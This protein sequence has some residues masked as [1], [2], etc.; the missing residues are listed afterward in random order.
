VSDNGVAVVVDA[1][2]AEPRRPSTKGVPR[3]PKATKGKVGV[4]AGA[5]CADM[6]LAPDGTNLER[7]E[8]SVLCLV[9][10]ERLDVG[11]SPVANQMQLA[12]AS[13]A[14]AAELVRDQ[15]WGHSS[16]SGSTLDKRA[17]ASGYTDADEWQVSENLGYG[18]ST[19]A[20]PRA[21]VQGWLDSPEHRANMLTP[22]YRD[23][24]VGMT[25]GLPKDGRTDGATVAA[26][27]GWREGVHPVVAGPR[28]TLA[29]RRRCK[30]RRLVARVVTSKVKCVKRKKRR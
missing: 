5:T 1:D 12:S 10:G 29:D 16:P 2:D 3:P 23:V 26:N 27:F 30:R 6:D 15:I 18:S 4:G 8:Q 24:G 21:I 7:A 14:W 19:R 13:K 28:I 22:E 9:N 17:I 25:P 11:L 20:T